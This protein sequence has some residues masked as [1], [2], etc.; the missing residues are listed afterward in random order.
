[1]LLSGNP[2]FSP[3]KP[4]TIQENVQEETGAP[5]FIDENDLFLFEQICSG[6]YE[7]TSPDWDHVEDLAKNFVKSA[8]V[9]NVCL[10]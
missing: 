4:D 9:V 5:V 1:M 6:S 3:Q 2:P 8:L 7:F 10:E